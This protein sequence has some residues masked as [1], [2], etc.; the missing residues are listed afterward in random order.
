MSQSSQSSRPLL[1]QRYALTHV[2]LEAPH[3]RHYAAR[4]TELG[5]PVRI[6]AVRSPAGGRMA[7]PDHFRACATSAARLRHVA[8]PLLRDFFCAEFIYYAVFDYYDGVSLAA[9]LA[10]QPRRSLCDALA[11]ALHLCD[12]LDYVARQTPELVPHITVSPDRLLR[13]GPTAIG[14]LDPGVAHWLTPSLSPATMADGAY[15]APE[16]MAGDVV[17]ERSIQ[18]SIA[19]VFYHALIGRALH[20]EVALAHDLAPLPSLALRSVIGK[21]LDPRPERRFASIELFGAALGWAARQMMPVSV[22]S[23][24]P[25]QRQVNTSTAGHVPFPSLA[26]TPFSAPSSLPSLPSLPAVRSLRQPPGLSHPLLPLRA[27]RRNG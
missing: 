8:L 3:Q 1:D 12:A 21:A 27:L 20:G 11:H 9:Y 26:A 6:I 13:Y 15:L 24:T 7:D 19:A 16:V 25:Q 18:Y 10:R 23:A 2:L 22:A 5:I 4:H 17:D 14:L